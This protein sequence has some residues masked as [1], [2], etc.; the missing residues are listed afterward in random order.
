M[1]AGKAGLAS[2]TRSRVP[3]GLRSRRQSER[4][5]TGKA[6]ANLPPP[7]GGGARASGRQGGRAPGRPTSQ[8]AVSAPSLTPRV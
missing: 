3:P 4:D 8:A 1:T 2:G 7:P 5:D 6:S